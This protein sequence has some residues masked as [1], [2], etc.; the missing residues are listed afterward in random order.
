MF[1]GIFCI[2]GSSKIE[3]TC[4]YLSIYP[5]FTICSCQITLEMDSK[6]TDQIFRDFGSDLDL[7]ISRSSNKLPVSV[8]EDIVPFVRSKSSAN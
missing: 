4:A 5:I 6:L 1:Y 8:V 2:K 7:E 3:Q